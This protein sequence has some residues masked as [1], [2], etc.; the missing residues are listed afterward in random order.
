M[1]LIVMGDITDIFFFGKFKSECNDDVIAHSTASF[2]SRG[3][4][5]F[6]MILWRLMTV[7]MIIFFLK[8]A[9]PFPYREKQAI[10]RDFRTIFDKENKE[11]DEDGFD[12]EMVD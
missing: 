7:T 4:T 1:T 6:I 11:N 12:E 3:L 10:L 9:R 8:H 2:V 5:Q